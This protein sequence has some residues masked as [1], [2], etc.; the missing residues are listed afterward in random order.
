V[1]AL[2]DKALAKRPDDL[3]AR[4]MKAKVLALT[5]RRAEALRLVESVLSSAP[6]DENA[7]DECLSYAIDLGDIQGAL[8]H[9]RRAVEVNPWSAVFHERLAYVSLE[10]QDWNEALHQSREALR[11]NPFLRFVRMFVV[12]CHLHQNDLKRATDEFSILI[13]L[14]PSLR[15]SLEAWFA[16]QKSKGRS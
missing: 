10:R 7:L 1:L 2:L 4:R 5:G 16:E 12:Q 9:A 6:A 3:L 11:L 14:N 15:E 13:K 8:A